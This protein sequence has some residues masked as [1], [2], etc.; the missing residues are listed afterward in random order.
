M[1]NYGI[2]SFHVINHHFLLNISQLL[3]LGTCQLQ[4]TDSGR[5]AETSAKRKQPVLQKLKNGYDHNIQFFLPQSGHL[6]SE[7]L[8]KLQISHLTIQLG[9]PVNCVL[10]VDASQSTQH[11]EAR[12]KSLGG[13]D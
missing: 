4:T 3:V 13:K 12:Q 1:R 6:H 8:Q 11:T 2:M 9:Q 10:D 5:A 7:K